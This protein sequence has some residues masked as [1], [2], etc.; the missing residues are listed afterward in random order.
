[1]I[2]GY[3]RIS[4][5]AQNIERQ[6]RNILSVYPTAKIHKEAYTGTVIARPVFSRLLSKLR[7]G[8]TMVCDS[9]SRMSRDASEGVETYM[10]LYDA[11]VNL[12]FLKE[13]HINSDTYRQA[14]NNQVALTGDA[15]DCILKGIN[16]YLKTLAKR[17]IEIAF[18]QSEKEVQ[19]LRQRTKEGM[20]TARLAGKQI[21]QQPGKKLTVKKYAL[22]KPIILK[23]CKC[24]GGSLSDAE[25]QALCGVSR[26]TFYEYKQRIKA[27]A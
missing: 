12:V 3:C 27:E 9:V 6:E 1:M 7:P 14:L 23:H 2:Y 16:E 11:G 25:V 22:A 17:Q 15:V 19:D 5:P 18:E 20:Q 13:P 8:D 24:F 4:T 10:Q 26:K 21:G